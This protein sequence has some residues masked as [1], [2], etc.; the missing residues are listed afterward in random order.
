MG[1]WPKVRRRS[2][3]GVCGCDQGTEDARVMQGSLCNSSPL[4]V[5]LL[6]GKDWPWGWAWAC[7]VSETRTHK[8]K[9]EVGRREVRVWALASN[10]GPDIY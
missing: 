4:P 5:G 3:W 8:G 9:Q 10:P 2:F 6:G 1:V 7:R